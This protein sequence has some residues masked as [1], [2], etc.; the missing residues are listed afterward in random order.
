VEED[1]VDIESETESPTAIEDTE[2]EASTVSEETEASTVSEEAETGASSDSE[3][4]ETDVAT[5]AET[6]VP[7]ADVAI[8]RPSGAPVGIWSAISASRWLVILVVLVLTG[9]GI[10]AGFVRKQKFTSD[11]RLAVQHFNFGANGAASG[12]STAAPTLADTY[13]RSID[14]D[15]VVNPLA[16]SYHLSPTTVRDDISAVAVPQSPVFTITATTLEPGLAIALA[17]AAAQ[18][19]LSYEQSVNSTNPAVP[20]L[21]RELQKAE[22]A[23]TSDEQAK[24]ALQARINGSLAAA[25]KNSIS[26]AQRASLAKADATISVAQDNVTALRSAYLQSFLSTSSPQYINPIQAATTATGDR[27]SRVELYGFVG[28]AVGIALGVALALLRHARRMR[29][30]AY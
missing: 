27:T 4:P 13:A 12:F 23:L 9:A 25:H 16:K 15:G 17:D 1:K 20:S 18:Q 10:A 5:A 28:L 22:S 3:G 24:N 7:D 26:L 8:V 6:R 21:Q 29:R 30:F 14:A 11:A 2:T 19:L